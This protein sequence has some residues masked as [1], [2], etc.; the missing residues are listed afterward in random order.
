MIENEVLG[1]LDLRKTFPILLLRLV[2]CCNRCC[3]QCLVLQCNWWVLCLFLWWC[4][5]VCCVERFSLANFGEVFYRFAMRGRQ[6]VS[7]REHILGH[8]KDEN[9]GTFVFVILFMYIK[10]FLKKSCLQPQCRPQR[11]GFSAISRGPHL[12]AISCNRNCD[13][14][15]KSYCIYLFY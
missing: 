4:S 9:L 10:I 13:R 3:W 14:S 7:S 12:F 11:Q 5:S 2:R 6:R 15:L 8:D 1:V